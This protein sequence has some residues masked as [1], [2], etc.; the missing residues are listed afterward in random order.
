MGDNVTIE[1]PVCEPSRLDTIRLFV[2][3]VAIVL[4]SAAYSAHLTSFLHAKEAILALSAS[5]L[6]ALTI[7]R[8]NV[9]RTG[10]FFLLPLL[11]VPVFCLAAG[12][13][14]FTDLGRSSV[15]EFI[16][17]AL[18]AAFVLCAFDLLEAERSRGPIRDAI[19][20]SA[21][22]VGLL[23]VLQF[24][25]IARYLFPDYDGNA[26]VLYSVFGN[27]GLLGGYLAASL[28]L[29]FYGMVE[30][31]RLHVVVRWTACAIVVA[32]LAL[33]GT[34]SAWAAAVA[35]TAFVILNGRLWNRRALAL[36]GA[37][38]VPLL[39]VVLVAPELTSG[40]V[41][42]AIHGSDP[43]MGLRY[44]FWSGAARMIREHPWAGVGPGNFG[45]YSPAAL[46][47]VLHGPGGER[48]VHNELHTVHAH[49]DFLELTAEL[50]IAGV[51]P[52]LWWFARLFR[53]PGPEWGVLVALLV[54]SCFYFPYYS[55]PHGLVGL[56]AAG[57]IFTRGREAVPRSLAKSGGR[58]AVAALTG[59][60]AILVFPLLV[61]VVILPSYRLRAAMNLHVAGED[62][63]PAYERV[64][65][66]AWA[67][68]ETHEKLG[69]ARFQAGD[70][71]EAEQEFTTALEGMDTGAVYMGLGAVRLQL[72][73]AT[74]AK[75]ALES[76]VYRWPSYVPAWELL[77]RVT[78]Q[79]DRDDAIARAKHWLDRDD[80]QTLIE[81]SDEIR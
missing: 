65:A 49:N 16:R 17:W 9:S 36:A 23:A 76:C 37:L 43:S 34:R 48:Y 46:A 56:L 20:G 35:G 42:D 14:G 4:C 11:F 71:E 55:L 33:S 12:V 66:Q 2:V 29:A 24:M 13:F 19:V 51:V 62:P 45:F 75:E 54:F 68:P 74:E 52:F 60:C 67:P 32:G 3:A 18:L 78:P 30:S 8:G 5:V 69:L 47:E 77:L 73:K 1:N 7:V 50:G 22:L 28:P 26:H 25:G 44:W 38:I 53:S 64:L 10:V 57:M 63:I 61:W 6:G 27:P 21:T 58:S 41:E 79:E 40:R 70:T 59:L 31:R 80:L 39:C 15:V 72:G 81:N